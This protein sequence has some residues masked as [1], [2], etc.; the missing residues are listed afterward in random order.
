L[1]A[2]LGHHAG[3]G[4]VDVVAMDHPNAGVVGVEVG[5]LCRRASVSIGSTGKPSVCVT[6][7]KM[8]TERDTERGVAAGVD[9]PDPHA[10]A[11]PAP[12]A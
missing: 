11:R 7:M 10:T 4:V 1:V 12:G 3:L 8:S 5:R 6:R 9:E 2:E